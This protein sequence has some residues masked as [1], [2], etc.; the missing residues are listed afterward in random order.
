[1]D[2]VA[3]TMQNNL[4][5]TGEPCQTSIQTRLEPEKSNKSINETNERNAERL[6][7][8]VVCR[9]EKRNIETEQK[10]ERLRKR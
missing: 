1:M 5:S 4:H 7:K 2:I 10:A 6:A 9:K 3:G 8:H